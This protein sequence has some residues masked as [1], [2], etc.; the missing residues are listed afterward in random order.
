MIKRS[1][2][3]RGFSLLEMLFATVILLAGLV[4][5]AQLIPASI[6]LDH[7]S[8]LNSGSLVFAQRELE[9][10]MQQPLAVAP[11]PSFS[12]ALGN[13]CIGADS[14]LLGDPSQPGV[15]VGSPVVVINNQLMVDF[16]ASTVAGYNFSYK[17]PNDPYGV[18]YDVRWA[19]ITEVNGTATT[20]RRF[21]LGVRQLGGDTFVPPVTLDSMVEK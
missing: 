5:V 3:Q 21:I 15:I 12:D 20:S 2:R 13:V 18:T 6:L 8:R 7:K 16:S 11:P 14:C 9:Q 17:D 19:V 10:M 1:P 4:G